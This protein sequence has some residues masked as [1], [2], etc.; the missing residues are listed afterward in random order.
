M[1]HPDA[2]DPDAQLPDEPRPDAGPGDAAPGDAL[3]DDDERMDRLRHDLAVANDL[4]E[5]PLRPAHGD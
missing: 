3:P 4:G 5:D 2:P 1:S